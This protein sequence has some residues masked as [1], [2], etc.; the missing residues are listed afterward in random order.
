MRL[1]VLF[2]GQTLVSLHAF[3]PCAHVGFS[4]GQYVG[5][6]PYNRF[7]AAGTEELFTNVPTGRSPLVMATPKSD[8]GAIRPVNP[9]A[10]TSVQCVTTLSLLMAFSL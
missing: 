7:Y 3:T 10:I 5:Y 8:T 4:E 2:V 1:I 6:R 9:R